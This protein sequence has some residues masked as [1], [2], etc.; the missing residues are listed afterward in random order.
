MAEEWKRSDSQIGSLEVRHFFS[1]AALYRDGAIVATLTPVGIAFKVPQ[2]V[3][4]E[5]L[6]SDRAVPLRYFPNSPVKS[7]YVLFPDS[8][9][10]SSEAV[11][12]LGM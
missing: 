10:E 9:L 1:G 2:D 4:E 8:S 12:L 3:R 11:S 6:K 5:L 7:D